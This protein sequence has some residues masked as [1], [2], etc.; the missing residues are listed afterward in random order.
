MSSDSSQ[1]AL[2]V[3]RESLD[4]WGVSPDLVGYHPQSDSAR[5]FPL[6]IASPP[7]LCL[8]DFLSAEECDTLI[9]TQRSNADES[10]LYLNARVNAELRAPDRSSSEAAE[11]ISEQGL[12]PDVLDDSAGSGF[13]TAVDPDAAIVVNVV[14]PRLQIALGLADRNIVHEEGAWVRPNKRSV[15]VR[16]MT[17]VHYKVGEGVAPHVDGKDATLLIYLNDVERGGSTTFPEVDVA[18][19]PARGT[20]LLY[21][22]K[23]G[24]LHYAER[25]RQGEKWV[26]QILVDFTYKPGEPVIDYRTGRLLE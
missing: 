3:F 25:V 2:D 13:R 6:R 5:G 12:S 10:D 19:K 7:I 1:R 14:L 26:M 20:A 22:S 15:V 4:Q 18:V 16:D 24:L 21:Q 11:L 17:S 8:P 23:K 9:G